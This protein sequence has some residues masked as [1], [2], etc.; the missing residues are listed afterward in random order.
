[1][2]QYQELNKSFINGEWVDGK[3]NTTVDMVNPYNNDI[4]AQVNIASLDQVNEAF[5]TAKKAQKS[6]RN[7]AAH[8][9]EVMTN[10]LEYFKENKETIM[11]ILTLES[12]ST[13]VKAN[14]EFDLTVGLM[15][16]SIKMVDEI[17][18]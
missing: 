13:Q 16:E 10:V 1:M 2:K 14:L 9:K 7:D 12:E 8:R 4:L 3:E 11:E 6:W 18:R 17:I 5:E 15:A